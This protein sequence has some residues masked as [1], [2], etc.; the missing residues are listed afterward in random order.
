MKITIL[1]PFLTGVGGA[2]KQ[3]LHLAYELSLENDVTVYT[4]KGTK[5][6]YHPNHDLRIISLNKYKY[7]TS[8]PLSRLNHTCNLLSWEKLAN[9]IDKDT[10]IINC[11]N[12]FSHWGAVKAKHRL[13]VPVLWMCNEIPG[14]YRYNY[15]RRFEYL[16]Y[17]EEYFFKGLD[18]RL[19]REIDGI[20]V[21]DTTRAKQIKY[22]YG[23]KAVII[24][25]GLDINKF[26]TGDG[27]QIRKKYKIKDS[28]FLA[29]S[30][31][32]LKA[33]LL[34]QK[35]YSHLK[36]M[37]AGSG[38]K[39]LREQYIHPRIIFTGEVK[40]E[41]LADFYS[42]CD[43]FVF[44]PIEQPWGLVVLEAMACGKPTIV[45]NDTGVSEVLTNREDAVIFPGGDHIELANALAELID[46]E[47]LRS[48]ISRNGKR[49]ANTFS[50]KNYAKN[51]LSEMRSLIGR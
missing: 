49:L 20:I 1:H 4:L 40:E 27:A 9:I 44:P 34:L 12:A 47:D 5:D 13:N 15:L 46:T 48:K 2:E 11:H 24:R 18:K 33:F 29:L 32:L 25:S 45:S 35:D 17:V 31:D 14:F 42:A 8:F 43:C 41:E 3:L 10:D 21:L 19:V 39:K 30:E 6:C 7:W 51:M 38:G 16:R 22:E 50:W 28:D 36:V 37:I 23:K 26:K